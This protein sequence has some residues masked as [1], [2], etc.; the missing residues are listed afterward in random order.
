[1]RNKFIIFGKTSYL[2]ESFYN[3]LLNKNFFCLGFG[4]RQINFLNKKSCSKV[5]RFIKKNSIIYFLSFNKI[6]KKSSIK[7]FYKNITLIKNFIESLKTKPKKIIF[8][9]SQVVYGEDTNNNNTTERTIPD[10]LSFYS[11]AKYTSERL[12]MNFC[13]NKKISFIIIRIP[14]VYGVNDNFNNYGPTMFSY[15]VKKNETI[16]VWGDGKEKRDYIFINDLNKILLKLSNKNFTGVLNVCS[17]K[18]ISFIGIIKLLEKIYKKKIKI[19]S[20]KRSRK[21]VNHIMNNKLLLKIIG[22]FKFT[23]IK[24]GLEI[25]KN[26][27]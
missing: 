22:R 23:S 15:K 9:S 3:Y 6:Q 14:R 26:Q 20:K 5:K 13:I 7:D 18:S 19:I 27:T 12:L 4:S 21:K 11:I 24:K 10:P 8:F 25:I 17:G 1:M 2:G 16:E